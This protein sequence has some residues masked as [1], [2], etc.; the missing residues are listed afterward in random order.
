MKKTLLLVFSL[1]ILACSK[2]SDLF[3]PNTVNPDPNAGVHVQD[4]MWKAMNYWYFWQADIPDLAD[5]RFA[6]TAEGSAEYTEFLDS[7]E[8][9]GAFFDNKLLFNEDRF[10]IHRED[11]KTLTQAQ[12]GISKSN[13]LEFGLVR[14]Q[15]SDE[16]VGYVWYVIP[17]SDASTKDIGRG[18]LFTGVNG[19]T[20]TIDNYVDLLFGDSDTYTLNM[21]D[22]ANNV[23][24]PND[25]DVTLTKFNGLVENPIFLSKIFELGGEKIGYLVYN[26]FTTEFDEELND[27]FSDFKAN[28]VSNLVLDLRYNPGGFVS[29]TQELSSMIYGTNTDELFLKQRWNEKQQARLTDSEITKYFVDKTDEGTPINTLNLNKV[30]ILATRSSASAS[31]LLMNGLAPYIEIVHIGRTT[32]GKNE[33]SLVMVDD[34]ENSYLYNASRENNINPDN[35]WAIRPLVG[36]NENADGFSDYTSGLVPTIDL[37]ED[38]SNMGVLGDQNEPLLARAIQEI[39]GITGKRGFEVQMPAEAMTNSKMFS[40]LKDDLILD[41]PIPFHME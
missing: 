39:T 11:Y 31:E 41:K 34:R 35:L 22:I 24:T 5:D 7:E 23:V 6:N 30:Y 2:D 17:N 29:S 28:G 16:L 26:Q 21:A 20:L 36:R 18:D 8:D 40:I 9:P 33:F 37:E 15:D 14:I 10:S 13:G 1:L 32:R 38:L 3:I 4:F 27:V 25:R 12:S 19:Q